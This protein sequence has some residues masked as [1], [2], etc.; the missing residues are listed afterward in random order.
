MKR[1]IP[2]IAACSIWAALAIGA[3]EGP[4]DLLALTV[5]VLAVVSGSMALY[6]LIR[7][8]V[9]PER[10]VVVALLIVAIP[11]VLSMPLRALIWGADSMRETP[12]WLV[13]LTMTPIGVAGMLGGLLNR[14]G[15]PVGRPPS[16]PRRTR[17]HRIAAGAAKLSTPQRVGENE[18][19][20][21]NRRV[22]PPPLPA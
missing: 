8:G 22:I 7:R 11:A 2:T 12:S 1:V 17:R 20:R 10:A 16:P 3:D 19:W 21:P 9:M 14:P 15:H 4:G 6:R 13:Y 18:P 5:W